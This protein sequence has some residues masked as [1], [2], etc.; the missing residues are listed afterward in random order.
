MRVFRFNYKLFSGLNTRKRSDDGQVMLVMGGEN[1]GGV[2]RSSAQ[3]IG[4]RRR[5]K[6]EES[7]NEL[8]R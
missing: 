6:H 1:D 2:F 5:R 3:I 8:E 7:C 4:R